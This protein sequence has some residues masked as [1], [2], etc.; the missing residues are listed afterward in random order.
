MVRYA[1]HKGM[2]PSRLLRWCTSETK[3]RPVAKWCDSLDTEVVNVVGIRNEES[4]ARADLGEWEW[5]DDFDRWT[6]RP[7]IRWTLQDVID[8][9]ARHGLAPNPL[10]L[11]GAERVGCWPCI[12]ARKAEIRFIADTDPVRIEVIRRLEAHVA[13]FA[14]ERI[15]AAGK[16]QKHTDPTWFQADRATL[17]ADGRTGWWWPIDNVVEWSRTSR[18]GKQMELFAASPRDAG[19]VRWGLCDTAPVKRR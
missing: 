3:V 1:L 15:E 11:R 10:Y 9:H 13:R 16:A 5:S 18:G 14:R 19:C 4:A 7:I 2:M 17:A 8:I 6:W 12:F